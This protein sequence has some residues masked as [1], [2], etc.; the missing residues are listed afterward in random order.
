MSVAQGLKLV[1]AGVTPQVIVTRAIL[2]HDGQAYLIL[3][4]RLG[5]CTDSSLKFKLHVWSNM[6]NFTQLSLTVSDGQASKLSIPDA[7]SAGLYEN[8]SIGRLPVPLLGARVLNIKMITRCCV[9][10]FSRG[11][12]VFLCNA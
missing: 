1:R 9:S 6:N 2:V 11:F 5:T 10:L 8:R 12:H 4:C 3:I 7:P